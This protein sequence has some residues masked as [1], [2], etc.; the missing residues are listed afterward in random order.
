MYAAARPVTSYA[1]TRQVATPNALRLLIEDDSPQTCRQNGAV[2]SREQV[3]VAYD[4]RPGKGLYAAA[5]SGNG[6]P[7]GRPGQNARRCE[8]LEAI[9]AIRSCSNTG[10]LKGFRPDQVLREIRSLTV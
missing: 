7:G 9:L 5:D 10:Q 3:P 1:S 2:T 8:K 4:P 6:E